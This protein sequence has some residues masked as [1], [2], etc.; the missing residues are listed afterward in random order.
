MLG[1]IEDLS[2]RDSQEEGEGGSQKE[3]KHFIDLPEKYDKWEPLAEII[4]TIVLAVATLAAAWS[5]YQSARWGGVQSINYTQAGALRTESLRASTKAGQLIQID[6]SLFTNWI[7]AYASD[8]ELL[9]KF[10][11][12]RFSPELSVAFD[13]W[14]ATDPA[15]N[16]NAPK[17]PFS[18]PEYKVDEV[19]KSDQ[20][21][22]EAGEM[23]TKG[24]AA[25]QTSDDYILNTVIL[26]SVLFLSGVQSKIKSSKLRMIVVILSLFI[27]A[28]GIYNIATYPIE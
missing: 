28:Y 14:I 24:S 27:L 11:E 8:N 5:G 10:Y 13:A 16:P 1:N 9:M 2:G 18:M 19:E 21:L 25:N 22:T 23:F 12:K 4:A 3:M 7:N 6:I 15:N 20:L 17:S 26:A